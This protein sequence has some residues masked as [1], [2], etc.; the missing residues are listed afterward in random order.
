VH[1]FFKRN[2]KFL[3]TDTVEHTDGIQKCIRV[4]MGSGPRGRNR[5]DV[6]GSGWRDDKPFVRWQH[7]CRFA[8]LLWNIEWNVSS[9]FKFNRMIWHGHLIYRGSYNWS[10]YL[11]ISNTINISRFHLYKENKDTQEALGVLGKMLG[12][13]VLVII[14]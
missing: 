6:N 5:R 8:V 14:F 2:F 10:M 13:Q 12:V 4:R 1:D 7:F 11:L 3:T 9:I